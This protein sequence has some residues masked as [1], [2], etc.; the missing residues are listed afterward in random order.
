[1]LR[2]VALW[3]CVCLL[4]MLYLL[5]TSC[6]PL[7]SGESEA[8]NNRP[9]TWTK[10]VAMVR[11]ESKPLLATE[12]P[13]DNGRVVIDPAQKEALL[14]E[15]ERLIATLQELSDEI[16]VIFRYQ[17]LLN[18][19][20][21]AAPSS[22]R[23]SIES[24][25]GVTMVSNTAVFHPP[26]PM[27][28]TAAEE[29]DSKPELKA[30]SAAFIGSRKVHEQLRATNHD[31]V[32]VPVRG[33]GVR[34]AIIDTGIDYTHKMFG[35]TGNVDDYNNNDPTVIEPDSFPTRK[36]I[37]GIDLVGAKY[38]PSA[39]D[40]ELHIP[41]GDP[42]PLDEDTHGTHVAGTTAGVGDG[43]N[44][45]D[46][47]APDANL[48]A[49]KVFG[50]GST[51]DA[52]VIKGLEYAI[53]P[54]GDFNLDDHAHVAN[55]SLGSPFGSP[56]SIYHEAIANALRGGMV[57]VAAAGNYGAQKYVAGDPSAADA[58]ISVAASI[59]DAE[60]N[61]KMP[62]IKFSSSGDQAIMAEAVES[63]MAKPIADVGE[64]T[65]PLYHIGLA[66]KD[67]SA[68]QV[69]GVRG[70]VA[71]IDRGIVTFVA[72]IN[73]ALAAGAVG[74]VVANN[75]EGAPI[76]MGGN[77]KYEIP[78]VMITKK[79]GERVKAA[80]QEHQVQVTFSTGLFLERRELIDTLANFSSHG[81]R[82]F[83]SLL[84]PEIAAPGVSI[85]SAFSG[86][87]DRG[88]HMSGTS[89]ASPHVAGVVALLRQYHRNL[90]A[91]QVKNMLV[92]NA[93]IMHTPA[94]E[95]YHLSQQGAGRVDAW[96]ALTAEV[97]FQPMALSLGRTLISSSKKIAGH[98]ALHNLSDK[99]ITLTLHP[100]LVPGLEMQ[101][102]SQVE[103]AGG[104]ETQVDFS[105]QIVAD[106]IKHH[107]SNMDGW[108]EARDG[109][110]VVARLPLLVAVQKLA[111]VQLQQAV[112][113]ADTVEDAY[114]AVVEVEL[115]NDGTNAGEALLFNLLDT[116]TREED[117]RRIISR[118]GE[119]CDLQSVG[120]RVIEQRIADKKEMVLQFAAKLYHPLTSWHNCALSVQFDADGDALADQ[121]LVGET[122]MSFIGRGQGGMF[123][124]ILADANK[125]REIRRNYESDGGM[126]DYTGAVVSILPLNFY[127]HS[128]LVVVSARLADI[129][130]NMDGDLHVRLTA[131]RPEGDDYLAQHAGSWQ[132]ITPTID[133]MGF[134]GMPNS[135]LVTQ[136]NTHKVTLIKGGDPSSR[137]I[138]YM[139]HNAS[140]F[141]H[142]RH[143]QQ[144]KLVE[145]RYQP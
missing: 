121:E 50:A 140:T 122:A 13:D 125:M 91:A 116:D 98:F 29:G 18:A 24:L 76:T 51:S 26:K 135:V 64:L 134:W 1:M 123:L 103:I 84:K 107:H 129:R 102:P 139:P 22:L 6:Q 68:E 46:G 45:H 58:A 55:L 113:H 138:A 124:S 33:E 16:N 87:G 114:Q 14:A 130:T 65:A 127:A 60:H 117:V 106:G 133:G 105:L 115:R 73:R 75:V 108:V 144:S 47:V 118:G 41:H 23:E 10:F 15:Q 11:L 82:G 96:R 74:V 80:M 85:I 132:R 28:V 62:A 136:G 95:R 99:N 30:N 92:A 12:T 79:K 61:W 101:I 141:S 71:L 69:E 90:N 78:A 70:K 42:D 8:I 40:F 112:I 100:N 27:L 72:K 86:R 37:A 36:V 34:V 44:T 142:L 110:R 104:A 131:M 88:I 111:R 20:T 81:P 35:G 143:D 2:V 43:I 137:L 89:M 128:T 63:P 38:D 3:R 19:L 21:I 57:V 109:E 120:Y 7:P 67:L 39:G 54:N 5:L 53:D 83:D 56:H 31:G 66:D 77:A 9:Q 17:L 94:G 59:D 93:K 126:A 4:S 32:L 97:I 49:I 25:E 145:L 48:L 119:T 52:V